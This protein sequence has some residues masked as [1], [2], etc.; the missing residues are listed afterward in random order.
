VD[1]LVEVVSEVLVDVWDQVASQT[2]HLPA[3]VAAWPPDH[4]SPPARVAIAEKFAG[5]DPGHA[6]L[7]L[8]AIV[9][10]A[11]EARRAEIAE[12]VRQM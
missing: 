2:I 6:G 8:T 4:G 9:M 11:R 7:P 12:R 10:N 1:T 5:F 3:P